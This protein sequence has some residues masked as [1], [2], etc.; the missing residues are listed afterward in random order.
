MKIK[1]E[2]IQGERPGGSAPWA[3][4]TDL[5]SRLC[6]AGLAKN[7][8]YAL[9]LILFTKHNNSTLLKNG[10]LCHMTR[11]F[12]SLRMTNSQLW[13]FFNNL[14]EAWASSHSWR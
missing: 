13:E 14:L 1:R 11:F 6:G 2:G 8:H 12:A 7:P 4:R 3:W 10:F 9:V 5:P